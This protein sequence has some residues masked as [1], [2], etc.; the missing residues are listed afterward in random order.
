MQPY[1]Y[2]MTNDY[3]SCTCR[4]VAAVGLCCRHSHKPSESGGSRTAAHRRLALCVWETGVKVKSVTILCWHT[5]ACDNR[6][7]WMIT[8][9]QKGTCGHLFW[10]FTHQLK[11]YD[12]CLPPFPTFWVVLQ[13]HTKKGKNMKSH[14]PYLGIH[15]SVLCR[16]A[17][18][19]GVY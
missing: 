7:H 2:Q 15:V 13:G 1:S 9:A 16:T 4:T 10:K 11:V 12:Y 18:Q 17:G 19:S 3:K 8:S 5:Q 6:S 14:H